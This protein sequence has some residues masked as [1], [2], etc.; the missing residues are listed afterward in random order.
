[1][2]SKP[3][4]P[5]SLYASNMKK[6]EDEKDLSFP[7]LM[8]K[9]VGLLSAKSFPCKI[10]CYIYKEDGIKMRYKTKCLKKAQSKLRKAGY[11]VDFTDE[12]RADVSF[13]QNPAY[14]Y[15]YLFSD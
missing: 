10:P 2:A 8:G 12:L 11:A 13:D 6:A 3:W 4:I 14:M 15:I 5:K 7:R 1:M 9:I